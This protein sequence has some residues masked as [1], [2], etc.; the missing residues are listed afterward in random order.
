MAPP[1][2]ERKATDQKIL[3]SIRDHFAPAVGTSDIAE[4]IE[5][6]RQ[7]ADNHLRDLWDE[8]MVDS[9][10]VGRSRIWW[11]TN[12]GRRLL[13]ELTEEDAN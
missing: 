7:T 12:E 3:R 2:P 11:I 8:G 10:K 4:S 6:S 13:S 9:I 1:G 5:V